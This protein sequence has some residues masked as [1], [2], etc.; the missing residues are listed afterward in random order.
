[1]CEA[2]V[3]LDD[4]EIMRDVVRVQCLP[5]GVRLTAFFEPPRTVPAAIREVDLLAHRVVLEP[6]REP[7]EP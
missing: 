7:E 6:L 1:M 3:Y 5:G 4:R 2:V